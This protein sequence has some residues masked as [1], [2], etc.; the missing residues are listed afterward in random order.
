MGFFSKIKDG[1]KAAAAAGKED[2]AVAAEMYKIFGQ[3]G[4]QVGNWKHNQ[5]KTKM[6]PDGS[7]KQKPETWGWTL[8]S[9]AGTWKMKVSEKGGLMKV[10]MNK[11]AAKSKTKF[12]YKQYVVNKGGEISI[13]NRDA[14]VAEC[15]KLLQ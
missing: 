12:K 13:K 14:L 3:L 5:P 8:T 4:Y 9:Q 15:R 6:K 7:M 2:D 1:V 10:N 11:G